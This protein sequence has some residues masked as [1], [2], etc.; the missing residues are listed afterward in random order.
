MNLS[1]YSYKIFHLKFC[2]QPFVCKERDQY[3]DSSD[4]LKKQHWMDDSQLRVFGVI[5]P[6][7]DAATP[8]MKS[9]ETKMFI[10]TLEK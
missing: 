8:N 1:H 5:K 4:N 2:F 3:L 7:A 10:S 6:I 9:I